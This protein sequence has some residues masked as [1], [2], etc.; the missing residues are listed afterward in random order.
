MWK[1]MRIRCRRCAKFYDFGNDHP[2]TSNNCAFRWH[3]MFLGGSNNAVF[4]GFCVEIISEAGWNEGVE[5]L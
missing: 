1:R 5:E 2:C 4:G 3:T